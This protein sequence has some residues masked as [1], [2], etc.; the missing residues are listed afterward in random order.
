MESAIATSIN[1]EE[2]FRNVGQLQSEIDERKE[3]I[4]KAFRAILHQS[5]EIEED[6]FWELIEDLNKTI[7]RTGNHKVGTENFMHNLAFG[8]SK[9][10]G[11]KTTVEDGFGFLVAYENMSSSISKPLWDVIEGFGDDGYGDVIDSFAFVH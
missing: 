8:H 10:G 5:E 3:V 1:F 11:E 4:A 2:T 6:K 7:K 9:V